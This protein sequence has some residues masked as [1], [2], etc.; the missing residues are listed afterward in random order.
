MTKIK[1]KT[2]NDIYDDNLIEF[3]DCRR[4]FELNLELRKEMKD[5]LKKLNRFKKFLLGSKMPNGERD[6]RVIAYI[7]GQIDFITEFFDIEESN[8]K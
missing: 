4:T 1:L 5:R 8:L 6:N 2:F 3:K 7:D